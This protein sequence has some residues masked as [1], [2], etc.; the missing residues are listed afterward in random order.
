MMGYELLRLV[1][2]ELS[3]RWELGND[4]FFLSLDELPGF[5]KR[6]D[7]LRRE[8]N[9]RKAHWKA[10]KRLYAPEV[11]DSENLEAIGRAPT[12]ESA[13][14]LRADPIAPGVAEGTA[15]IV[16]DPG[17]ARD[18]GVDSILVCPSTDPGWTPLFMH[19]RGLIVER[20]G[21]LSH[22]AIVARDF[23]I[24]AV[25]C[26]DA[27]RLL[28]EGDAVQLDGNRG[29]IGLPDRSASVRAADRAGQEV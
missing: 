8:I 18:L 13:A 7:S 6:R 12:L 28:R 15:R 3:R 2:V 5:E 19:A 1:L 4:I 23:G 11:I 10:L 16:F 21:V 29:I 26:P 22:G 20:G 27:T 14:E 9:E 17:E 25:V 24:P